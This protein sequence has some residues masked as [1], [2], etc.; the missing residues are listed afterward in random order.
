M[1]AIIQARMGAS[2]FPAKM[3]HPVAGMPLLRH[4]FERLRGART[5]GRIVVA[6]TD[7]PEDDRLEAFCRSQGV[8]VFRGSCDRVLDRLIGAAEAFG[9]TRFLRV[10]ADNPLLDAA[11]ADAV[12]EALEADVDYASHITRNDEPIILKPLGICVEGVALGALRKVAASATDPLAQE[13]VTMHIYRNPDQFNIRWVE[14][15]EWID[16][17]HRLTI[18]YPIDVAPIEAILAAHPNPDARRIMAFLEAN[19]QIAEAMRATSR[20]FPKIY[21]QP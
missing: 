14:I 7:R 20:K 16:P 10:C 1:D 9:C 17:E 5:I 12:S 21:P 6:T 18:D 2:R 13:H 3:L 4:V 11:M 15:P 19:A 8:D